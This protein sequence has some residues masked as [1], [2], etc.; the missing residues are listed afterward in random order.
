[1]TSTPFHSGGNFRFGRIVFKNPLD[2][3]GGMT[4]AATNGAGETRRSALCG[5][6]RRGEGNELRQ[7]PRI[8]GGG[9][10]EEFVFRSAWT[11]QA[12]LTE[13]EDGASGERR[14]S[15]P[16]FAPGMRRHNPR[17]WRLR[18][19]CHRRLHERSAR[20]CAPACSGSISA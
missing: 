13:S 1:V 14:A 8:L 9:G 19:P 3:R 4:V 15:R 6:D 12:Q 16:S 10:Q 5:E 18:G 2:R 7:F 20:S 11:A 17:S